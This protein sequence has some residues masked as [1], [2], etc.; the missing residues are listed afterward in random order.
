MRAMTKLDTEDSCE[1]MTWSAEVFDEAALIDA[2]I[3]WHYGVPR[4]VLTVN[5]VK[6][7]QYARSLHERVNLWPGCR[8]KETISK[9]NNGTSSTSVCDPSCA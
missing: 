9:I 8:A 5:A 4:D 6:L 2:V 3:N 7:S 1:R